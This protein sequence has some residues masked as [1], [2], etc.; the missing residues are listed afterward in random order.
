MLQKQQ[1]SGASGSQQ[2]S[3]H[4]TQ[5]RGKQPPMREMKTSARP[6]GARAEM[7]PAYTSQ[8]QRIKLEKAKAMYPR[9]PSKYRRVNQAMDKELI[10]YKTEIEK[11]FARSQTKDFVMPRAKDNLGIAQ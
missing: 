11:R 3:Q 7:I 9:D 6:Q 1:K 2:P 8:E 5:K 4:Q 10:W